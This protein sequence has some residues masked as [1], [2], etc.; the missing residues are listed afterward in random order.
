MSPIKLRKPFS[1]ILL[2]CRDA[3]GELAS[4][5]DAIVHRPQAPPSALGVG[6]FLSTP[7]SPSREPHLFR[8]PSFTSL[9]PPPPACFHHLSRSRHPYLHQPL[10]V[11]P[12]VWSPGPA[13]GPSPSSSVWDGTWRDIP[14]RARVGTWVASVPSPLRVS[15]YCS[16]ATTEKPSTVPEIGKTMVDNLLHSD[17]V[18]YMLAALKTLGLHVKD[19]STLK[20]AVVE[21]CGGQF[22]VGK[23]A[24]EV[25]LFL[26]GTAKRPLTAAVTAAG[27]NSRYI[28]DGVPRMRE[29]PIGDLVSSLKQLGGDVDC[30]LG[31]NS[32]SVLINANGGL[33]GGPKKTASMPRRSPPPPPSLRVQGRNVSPQSEKEA[34]HSRYSQSALTVDG[35]GGSSQSALTVDGNGGPLGAFW[36]TLHA[37]T[38]F[39]GQLDKSPQFDEDQ[40][41]VAS[42]SVCLR[43]KFRIRVTRKVMCPFIGW[44]SQTFK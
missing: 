21:G 38:G 18:Q 1:R 15:A 14:P 4:H 17:D 5:F 31:T 3:Q 22:P 10:D 2:S 12:A 34:Q 19:D 23:N 27:G 7:P 24:N 28:L 39:G 9:A 11:S 6:C 8:P 37:V 25:K 35:N 29:R 30:I 32:P 33:P 40:T 44:L 36:S 42:I 20:R 13:P 43:D 16:A 41:R 26:A